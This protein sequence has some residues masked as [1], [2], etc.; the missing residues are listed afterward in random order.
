LA[1]LV[2]YYINYGLAQRV[3]VEV[4]GKKGRVDV[5]LEE[6]T[7]TRGV[8]EDW[9]EERVRRVMPT[10]TKGEEELATATETATLVVAPFTAT[11]APAPVSTA[12]A[13]ATSP[14]D[15]YTFESEDR[16]DLHHLTNSTP[17][18]P[19]PNMNEEDEEAEDDDFFKMNF[20]V[21]FV[22][23]P[24]VSSAGLRV[25]LQIVSDL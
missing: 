15:P 25:G 24:E 23:K 16:I 22:G 13:T 7:V 20:V 9:G 8:D 1:Y 5:E 18:P 19:P 11:T 6:E 12:T 21:M 2:G 3:L 10:T 14:A 17:P 4:D